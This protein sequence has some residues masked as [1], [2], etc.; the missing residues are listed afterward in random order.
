MPEHGVNLTKLLWCSFLRCPNLI[1][2]IFTAFQKTLFSRR[3]LFHENLYLRTSRL[4]GPMLSNK[5][6][7]N[8]RLSFP[9]KNAAYPP[10]QPVFLCEI[11]RIKSCK[12]S[13]RLPYA[14]SRQYLSVMKNFTHSG[15]L[16]GQAPSTSINRQSLLSSCFANKFNSFRGTLP[17]PINQHGGDFT[18]RPSTSTMGSQYLLQL[19][20]NTGDKAALG[21]HDPQFLSSRLQQPEERERRC[22]RL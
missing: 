11:K 1:F 9:E 17:I 12:K 6:K 13:P 14:I 16:P 20:D 4:P 8:Y 21:G 5:G 18:C 22:N 3:V 10:P 7:H 19:L 15:D 2:Q